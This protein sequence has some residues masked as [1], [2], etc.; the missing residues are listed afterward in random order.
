MTEAKREIIRASRS[1]VDDVIINHFKLFKD[2]IR[3]EQVESWRPSD[4]VLKNYQMAINNV[5]CKIQ[6]TIDG[7]RKRLNKLKDEMISIYEGMLDNDVYE[8]EQVKDLEIQKD[9]IREKLIETSTCTGCTGCTGS[10]FKEM[11]QRKIEYDNPYDPPDQGS[12]YLTRNGNP[13][14]KARY[15]LKKVDV[16]PNDK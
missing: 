12:Y 13:S 6:R 1:K 15:Y 8:I 3:I 2:G 10:D 11:K 14:D 16:K 9:G 7:L 4:K 5:F